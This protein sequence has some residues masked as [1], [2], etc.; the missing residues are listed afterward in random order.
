M[1]H[2]ASVT[3]NYRLQHRAPAIG[4]MDVAR[5]QHTP[6][7]IAELVEHEQRMITGAGKMAI[8]GTAFLLSVSRAFARI[9]VEHDGLRRSPP[10]HFVDPLTGQIG[11]SNK[12]LGPAEPLRFETPHLAGRGGTSG[13]RLLAYHPAHRRV[14]A[15][16]LGIVHVL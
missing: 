5:P 6:L 12:V 11:E 2:D 1:L 7:D 16:P 13:D 9:H 4:A 10:A 14:A 15:Q 3:S 8:V